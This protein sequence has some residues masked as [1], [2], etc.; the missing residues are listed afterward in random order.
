MQ[1]H[2]PALLSWTTWWWSHDAETRTF[3]V[4]LSEGS[5]PPRIIVA[6]P[7]DRPIPNSRDEHLETGRTASSTGVRPVARAP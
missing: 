3:L 6:H 5:R 7:A 1:R 2:V 4:G